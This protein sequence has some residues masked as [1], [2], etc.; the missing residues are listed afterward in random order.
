MNTTKLNCKRIAAVVIVAFI[1]VLSLTVCAACGYIVVSL[2][3]ISATYSGDSVEVGGTLDKADIV[4]TAKYS[5]NTSKV[6]TNYELNYDFSEAGQ[7]LVTVSYGYAGQSRE[8]TFYVTVSEKSV[9][10]EPAK[11]LE[12]ITAVYNGQDVE[13]GGELSKSDIAVTAHY[14]DNGSKSVTD[15]TYSGFDSSAAGQKEVTVTYVENDVTKT[16]II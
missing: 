10:P 15:F 16:A 6:V 14:S 8:A 9:D 5:N 7:R 3:E 13:L 1:L 2:K 11:T 12:S 4:V